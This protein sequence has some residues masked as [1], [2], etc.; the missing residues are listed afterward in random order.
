MS[1]S[2]RATSL[3]ARARSRAGMGVAVGE[4]A[5]AAGAPGIRWRAV[6]GTGAAET[7]GRLSP[8]VD[9]QVRARC[10]ATTHIPS[11]DV[12]FG[13]SADEANEQLV[14]LVRVAGAPAGMGRVSHP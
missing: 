3:T 14:R 11:R 9:I 4:V 7:G 8:A 1:S 2:E 10:F 5:G 6:S 13:S 12:E